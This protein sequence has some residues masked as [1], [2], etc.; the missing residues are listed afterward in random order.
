MKPKLLLGLALVLSGGLF[1]CSQSYP[2]NNEAERI[3]NNREILRLATLIDSNKPPVTVEMLE[4]G[5]FDG[6]LFDLG[7]SQGQFTS[8][9]G[10]APEN[11]QAIL[12][13]LMNYSLPPENH[14][15]LPDFSI[16]GEDAIREKAAD[17]LI[18]MPSPAVVSILR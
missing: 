13:R 11:T 16:I 9:L 3:E 1:G 2:N 12:I 17:I 10:T 7:L 18:A 8:Y 4:T 6:R 14:K 5:E 15:M